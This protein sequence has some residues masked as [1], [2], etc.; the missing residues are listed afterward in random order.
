LTYWKRKEKEKGKV[1]VPDMIF[2]SHA[3]VKK[4]KNHKKEKNLHLPY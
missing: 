3:D 1:F 4:K 2:S